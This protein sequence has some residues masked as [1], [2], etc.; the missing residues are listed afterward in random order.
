MNDPAV[1][2][3]PNSAT[4]T[5]FHR[6]CLDAADRRGAR[7]TASSPS[8][9]PTAPR[10]TRTRSGS[11]RTPTATGSSRRAASRR[12]N[13]RD[14]PA[15]T[16]ITPQSRRRRRRARRRLGRRPGDSGA[17]GLAPTRRRRPPHPGRRP[18]RARPCGPGPTSA[19]PPTIDGS[20]IL[21]DGAV[22]EEWL[23]TLVQYGHLPTRAHPDRPRFRR[24]PRRP[25]RADPR[26]QLRS[27]V[28]RAG[29]ARPRLDGIHRARPRAAH[30][31]AHPRGAARLPVPPLHR[32]HRRGWLV[33]DERRLGGRRG[34]P[35][36]APRRVRRAHHPRLGVLQPGQATPSTAG[37]A[38][39]STTARAPA[40]HP[41]GVLPGPQL[42]PHMDRADIPRALR[43][44]PGVRHDGPRSA[45]PDSSTR[46]GPAISSGS[47]TVASSTVA[48][49]SR[50]AAR[51]TCAAP[52]PTTT[53]SIPS[54]ESA[55]PHQKGHH[56][57]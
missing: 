1:S 33:A 40:A 57:R 55:A 2:E 14:L 30:R 51:G 19:E 47:T 23:T 36:R 22:F 7:R 9:G 48:T 38:R 6:P 50:S 29:Q 21:D 54:Y 24:P 35:R 15:P 20:N 44:A 53:T 16:A 46:S 52:T 45:L 27:G 5:R 28:E 10:S 8:A 42:A 3:M 11:P 26:H 25:R 41:A 39:S 34:D 4:D 18:P 37:S 12:S 13:P 49:R 56:S 31:P 43:V 17:P 32:E